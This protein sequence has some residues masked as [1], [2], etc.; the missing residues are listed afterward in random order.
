MKHFVG[1]IFKIHHYN[2]DYKNTAYIE[3]EKE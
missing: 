1:N 2:F 3:I